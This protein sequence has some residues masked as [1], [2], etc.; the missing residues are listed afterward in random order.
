MIVSNLAVK[1]LVYSFSSVNWIDVRAFQA[2]V[3]KQIQ[4]TLSSF[5]FFN[6]FAPLILLFDTSNKL[7]VHVSKWNTIPV[8]FFMFRSIL[9]T[10]S[11]YILVLV[12]KLMNKAWICWE[13]MNIHLLMVAN[14]MTSNLI[15]CHSPRSMLNVIRVENRFIFKY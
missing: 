14:T 6:S 11:F 1:I 8:G 13:N 7:W 5:I 4:L 10:L 15:F 3:F 2:D 9:T 12:L